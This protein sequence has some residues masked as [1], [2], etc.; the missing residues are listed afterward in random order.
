MTISRGRAKIGRNN[1]FNDIRKFV[2]AGRKM[3]DRK[4]CRLFPLPSASLPHEISHATNSITMEAL[5]QS[6][7]MI[8]CRALKSMET[9][10][11]ERDVGLRPTPSPFS[12]AITF[13]IE[14]I[15]ETDRYR[16]C[17]TLHGA[18][19]RQTPLPRSAANSRLDL[20]RPL[21]LNATFGKP[22][23]N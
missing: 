20:F 10:T 17:E 15:I 22:T 12:F 21:S 16:S 14:R 5:I 18:R 23:A 2:N 6:N 1:A 19:S 13:V 7:V 11:R 3:I 4:R 9:K 8:Q